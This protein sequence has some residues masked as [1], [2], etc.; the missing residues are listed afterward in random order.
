MADASGLSLT[1]VMVQLHV[2]ARAPSAPMPPPSHA[3]QVPLTR[4]SK[5]SKILYLVQGGI[6]A[7]EDPRTAAMREL[8]EETGMCSAQILSEHSAWLQY[9]FP[10]GK[11]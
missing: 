10:P 5:H 11:V 3:I 9:D 6:D 2:H 1:L 7:G 4:L 8:T